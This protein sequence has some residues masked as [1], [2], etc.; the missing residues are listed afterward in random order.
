MEVTAATGGFNQFLMFTESPETDYYFV[1][2]GPMCNPSWYMT[3]DHWEY[4]DEYGYMTHVGN[5]SGPIMRGT[6]LFITEGDD[7]ENPTGMS[8]AFEVYDDAGYKMN[9]TGNG[10]TVTSTDSF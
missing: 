5:P 8:I 10:L 3:V 2:G 9:F 6:M 4:S 7:I 1:Q